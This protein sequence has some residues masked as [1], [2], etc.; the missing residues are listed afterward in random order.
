MLLAIQV[1]PSV[2]IACGPG[3]RYAMCWLDIWLVS[4]FAILYHP[5]FVYFALGAC[6]PLVVSPKLTKG[7]T[8]N[9]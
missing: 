2:S 6:Q 1:L 9:L 8:L 3:D 5:L 4:V 7:P